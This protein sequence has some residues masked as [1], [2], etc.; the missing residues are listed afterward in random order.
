MQANKEDL[1]RFVGRS[2]IGSAWEVQENADVLIIINIEKKKGTNQYYLTFKRVKIRYRE[3]S[4]LGYFNHPFEIGNRM[5]LMDDVDLEQSLSEESLATDFEGVIDINT[6]RGKRNA[7]E[8][9][10][11]DEDN[12]EEL[13][14]FKK[15]VNFGN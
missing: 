4:D 11:V 10:I 3:Q 12:D 1:A 13:F 9:E 15:A 2:N 8:R 5:K 6:K 7:K 14:D